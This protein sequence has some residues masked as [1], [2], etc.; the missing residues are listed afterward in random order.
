MTT[1]RCIRRDLDAVA[2]GSIHTGIVNHVNLFESFRINEYYWTTLRFVKE[3][4]YNLQEG[5]EVR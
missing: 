5:I 2:I 4:R 1:I 3:S